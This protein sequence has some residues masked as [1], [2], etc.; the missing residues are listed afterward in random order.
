MLRVRGTLSVVAV[1]VS[2]VT[3]QPVL[4]V[5]INGAQRGETSTVFSQVT[6]TGSGSA[7]AACW[8]QLEGE[9]RERREEKGGEERRRERRT[10]GRKEV[11]EWSGGVAAI[12]R[13]A[14]V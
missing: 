1:S 10:R 2:T 3:G 11:R 14:V 6:V 5:G 4:S 12:E 8:P 13:A 9:E 7:H